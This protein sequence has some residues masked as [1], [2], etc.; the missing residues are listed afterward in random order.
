MK[1]NTVMNILLTLVIACVMGGCDLAEKL[2]SSNTNKHSPVFN[3]SSYEFNVTENTTVVGVVDATDAD[4]DSKIEY[5]VTPNLFLIDKNSGDLSFKVAQSF[6]NGSVYTPVITA[7]DG[8]FST[9]ITV[10]V[11]IIQNT[12]NIFSIGSITTPTPTPTPT[13]TAFYLVDLQY[14]S[15]PI[16]SLKLAFDD[17][18]T[19]NLDDSNETF[20][21]DF[22]GSIDS[23]KEYFHLYIEDVSGV[24]YFPPIIK[25]LGS[26]SPFYREA[27]GDLYFL[28][29]DDN[30]LIIDFCKYSNSKVY[31]GLFKNNNNDENYAL[32][33]CHSSTDS[34]SF[35][36][37]IDFDSLDLDANVQSLIVEKDIEIAIAEATFTANSFGLVHI[38]ITSEDQGLLYYYQIDGG[39]IMQGLFDNGELILNL[40]D[41][42]SYNVSIFAKD[43]SLNQSSTHDIIVISNGIDSSAGYERNILIE[44]FTADWCGPCVGSSDSFRDLLSL[45]T[46]AFDK[47]NMIRFG[48][49]EHLLYSLSGDV[50]DFVRSRKDFY[51]GVSSVPTVFSNGF[52]SESHPNIFQDIQRTGLNFT[53]YD[54]NVDFNSSNDYIDVTISNLSD[55]ADDAI[56][57]AVIVEDSYTYNQAPG[58][59]G[60]TYFAHSLLDVF[61]NEVDLTATSSNSQTIT[62]ELSDIT[63]PPISWNNDSNT[64]IPTDFSFII[65]IQKTD[66]SKEVLQSAKLSLDDWDGK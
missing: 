12:I 9:D 15:V 4:K 65:F 14:D 6:N 28:K 27:L 17:V 8:E 20:S 42:G 31:M 53:S 7:F 38:P 61:D 52:E 39:D 33:F 3:Q 63:I 35:S 46:E 57:T 11:N 47:V 50:Q 24:D 10:T 19:I 59:N 36:T 55:S 30:D 54:I 18:G 66:G 48:V 60:Q 49:H 41:Q 23:V 34:N 40:P 58:S 5:S 1:K 45:D 16:L 25:F 29:T 37:I 43:Y 2:D 22:D 51:N 44:K 13:P 64:R 56:I 32:I 21:I 62:Y 26:G